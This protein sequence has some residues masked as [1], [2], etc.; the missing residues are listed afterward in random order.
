[1]NLTFT[2]GFTLLHFL[3]QGALIALLLAALNVSLRNATARRRYAA[4]CAAL[5]L[6]LACAVFTFARLTSVPASLATSVSAPAALPAVPSSG[7]QPIASSNA[8]PSA[9]VAALLPW[10]AYFWMAGV[11]LLAA[12]SLGGWI[13]LQRF[14]RRNSHPAAAAWQL[15]MKVLARRLQVS[16]PV[17][18]C[19]SA[20]AQVPA[21]IGWIRPV[22]LMPASAL[23]GLTA[24]QIESLLAHEL[25]HIR[26]HDYLV[27]LLQ[28]CVETLLFYHPAVWW[29]GACIR[30]ERENCCDDLAVEVSGDAL[31]YARALACMEQ[32][33]GGVPRLAMAANRGSLLQRIQRLLPAPPTARSTSAGW[34]SGAALTLLLFAF[35]ISPRIAHTSNLPSAQPKL[36][37][38][39]T[40]AIVTSIESAEASAPAIAAKQSKRVSATAPVIAPAEATTAVT[41]AVFQTGTNQPQ[42]G[43]MD[44]MAKA[45]YRDLTVDQL[46]AMKIHG[47]NG[48]YVSKLRAAGL[49]PGADQLLAMKIH[50]VTPEYAEQLKAKGWKLSIDQLLAFRIHGVDQPEL[51]KMA[52]LGYKLDADQALAM[53][54]HGLNAEMAR[55][56]KAMGLGDPTFD[57]L[58][59]MKIHGADADYATAIQQTGIREL[60]LDRLLALKIHGGNPAQI[61]E[62]QSLGFQDLNADQIVAA[63]IHG[64]TPE[65]IR[66][67]RKRGYKDQTFEQFIRLK[68]FGI[69]DSESK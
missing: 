7:A 53:R 33:R 48:E 15:R 3:W 16:R 1:M 43:F 24:G 29:V 55:R 18:L 2:L 23:S 8:A 61:R 67:T 69:L 65:F 11:C 39:G 62:F 51:D 30:A 17:R 66:E 64:V 57:Q 13:T 59:A 42:T 46:I 44:E 45:G 37:G 58:L 10:L 60:N 63:R 27:N 52:A 20:I 21:V 34:L 25:A 5:L 12:R 6:M 49:Q 50:G 9:S 35:W 40:P 31:A 54:I 19:E 47:V 14:T 32:L 22:I 38:T 26:R 68:Q 28:T 36:A 56:V 4:A 41:A